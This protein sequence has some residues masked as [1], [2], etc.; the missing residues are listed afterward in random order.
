MPGVAKG[1]QRSDRPCHSQ[2]NTQPFLGGLLKF[3][4]WK[5]WVCNSG[6]A[7]NFPRKEGF[8]FELYKSVLFIIYKTSE[9]SF[10]K[11]RSADA[12]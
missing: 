3:V 2:L 10:A 6:T 7:F 4:I 8:C 12:W 5:V 1:K 9:N 11:D